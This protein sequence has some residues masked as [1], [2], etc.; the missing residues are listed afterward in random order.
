MSS[1]QHPADDAGDRLE[2]DLANGQ[3]PS[4]FDLRAVLADL[5]DRAPK[6]RPAPA[7]PAEPAP[8]A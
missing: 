2:A 4:P 8:A 6:R 7:E 1:K 3:P 5:R